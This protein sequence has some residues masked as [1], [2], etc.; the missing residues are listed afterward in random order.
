MTALYVDV[1]H[2]DR[3]R[4][5][6]PLDW[7]A[8]AA[9]GVPSVMLARASYGDPQGFHPETRFFREH[10]AGAAA[11]G[12]TA[13][14]GYHNLIH[15]DA[16][17]IGRQVDY[18]R[19]E[20]DAAGATFAM[21]DV[22]RYPALIANGLYPRWPD[23]VAFHDRWAAVDSRVLCTYLAHWVWDALGAPDLTQLPGP[24]TN[25]NYPNLTPAPPGAMYA[26]CAGNDGVG[27]ASY[28]GRV[29]DFW[30]FTSTCDLSRAGGSVR[31]DVNAYR[32]SLD[33]LIAMLGGGSSVAYPKRTIVRSSVLN[34]MQNGKLPDSILVSTPGAA[35]GATVRLITPAAR[36]WRAFTARAA[37]L[38]HI[39]KPTSAADSYRSYAIQES[40]FRA[41]YTTTFLSG[42]PY[43]TWNGVRWYQ[44]P[45]T[46]M[47][48]VP[49]TSNHGWAMAIDVGEERDSDAAAEALDTPTLNWMLANEQAFG[50]MHGVDGEPWHIDYFA[51]DAIPAAVLAHEQGGTTPTG[52][53]MPEIM[54]TVTD[55]HGGVWL[56]NY[57]TYRTIGGDGEYDFHI[58]RGVTEVRVTEAQL[59]RYGVPVAAKL[60]AAV[61]L[62]ETDRAAIIAEI[63]EGIAIPTAAEIA[64]AVA[65]EDH[66]RS[67]A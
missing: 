28:G 22:E 46:A 43:K 26:A 32:G 24:L 47:A 33:D 63:R 11:A 37:A 8:I 10:Q 34:G 55:G 49:G 27:W 66:R 23:V 64:E 67:E 6:A 42:R 40:T 21:L 58:K 16:A 36:A 3:D 56:S 65:D 50:F 15:G 51:G 2:Y 9:A 14:G 4:R 17:C 62:S 25:A 52:D 19:G 30:Q 48:A 60:P 20:L 5:G 7:A 29:P 61:S 53:D 41:R 44:R 45:N 39:L 31:T 13:R 57:Q 18:L 1:S 59:A 35:G 38:G 12:F 54:V